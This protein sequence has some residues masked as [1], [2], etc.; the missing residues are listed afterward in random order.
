MP[1]R[2][3]QRTRPQR[4]RRPSCAAVGVV[5]VAEQ[6]GGRP[7]PAW[8]RPPHPPPSTR[9][10]DRRATAAVAGGR[11]SHPDDGPCRGREGPRLAAA[12]VAARAAAPGSPPA[13]AAAPPPPPPPLPP[14]TPLPHTSRGASA[15]TAPACRH[16]E[17]H[18]ESPSGMGWPAQHAHA[19]KPA[20]QAAKTEY[21]RRQFQG[22]ASGGA[23]ACPSSAKTA[24]AIARPSRMLP[25]LS[26]R[27]SRRRP[28]QPGAHELPP[29]W[30]R[31]RDAGA[32]SCRRP[33]RGPPHSP[34]SRP[35]VPA[36][37][38]PGG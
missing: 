37:G 21:R 3:A 34:P 7:A 30:L 26:R 35:A 20:V 12:T 18:D 2:L 22:G 6:T 10:L 9:A 16:G 38:Q 13:G 32:L 17:S 8:R 19:A 33:P 23:R 27:R 15:R 25:S 14:A 36:R 31:W 1:H 29:G 28:R 4:R 5:T 11:A 24:K